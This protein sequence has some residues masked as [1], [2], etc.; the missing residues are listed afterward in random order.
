[1]SPLETTRQKILLMILFEKEKNMLNGNG[2]DNSE[3]M[4]RQKSMNSGSG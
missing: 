4:N 1:M 2:L 3:W